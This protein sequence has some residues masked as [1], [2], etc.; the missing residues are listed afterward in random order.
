MHSDILKDLHE[1][2]LG[3][4]L[5]QENTLARLKERF[6]WPG[7]FNDVQN[8]CRT[9]ATCAA[10]KTPAPKASTP[11]QSI[12]PGYPLQI[13]AVDILGPLPETP[14]GNSYIL[15]ISPVGWRHALP[16][17]EAVTVAKKI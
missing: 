15:I 3:G 11:L 7:Y 8:W 14:S 12:Q 10:H 9:C 16:N 6:Y 1:G 2:S 5:G 17:Q 13:V 4:Y